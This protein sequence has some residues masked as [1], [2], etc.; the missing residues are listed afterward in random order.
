MDDETCEILPKKCKIVWIVL[1]FTQSILENLQVSKR[2]NST[3][4]CKPMKFEGG[5]ASCTWN[6]KSLQ[7]RTLA[8]LHGRPT[9]KRNIPISCLK[10]IRMLAS[11]R[12]EP[13]NRRYEGGG[14]DDDAKSKVWNCLRSKSTVVLLISLFVMEA[15]AALGLGIYYYLQQQDGTLPPLFG[16]TNTNCYDYDDFQPFTGEKFT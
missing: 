7:G 14:K 3:G 10:V 16:T 4:S 11:N 9:S 2:E 15:L 5:S 6:D 13:S 1:I 12:F 8:L